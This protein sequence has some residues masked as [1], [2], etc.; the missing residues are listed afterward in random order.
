MPAHFTLYIKICFKRPLKKKTKI[1]FQDR[2]SLNAGKKYCSKENILQYFRP[3]LSYHLSL[4]S[5]FE[6]QHVRQVLPYTC[7]STCDI[8]I[9]CPEPWCRGYKTIFVLYSTEHEISIAHKTKLLK[10]TDFS[11]FQTL[12]C[13]I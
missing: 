12:R 1:G 8:Y 13:C 7:P 5:I 2:I 9:I 11:C 6:W 3:I 4:G 10:N